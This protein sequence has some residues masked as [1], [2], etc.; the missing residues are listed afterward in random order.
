VRGLRVADASAMPQITT[1]N[2]NAPVIMIGEK[3]ADM[4]LEEWD[5]SDGSDKSSC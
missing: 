3:M 2:T 1:G 5:Q 4:L